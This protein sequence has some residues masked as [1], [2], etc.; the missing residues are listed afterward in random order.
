MY[1]FPRASHLYLLQKP[2]AGSQYNNVREPDGSRL[3]DL[4]VVNW[5]N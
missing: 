1:S 5:H 4:R 3:K 2:Y